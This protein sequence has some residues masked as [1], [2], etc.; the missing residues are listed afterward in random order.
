MAEPPSINAAGGAPSPLERLR[1][2]QVAYAFAP[3]YGLHIAE[4]FPRFIPWTHNFPRVYGHDMTIASFWAGDIMFIAYVL[5][6]LLLLRFNRSGAGVVAALSVSVW[7]LSNG[8]KHIAMTLIFNSYSPGAL[9]AAGL[10]LP[11]SVL[12]FDRAAHERLLTRRRVGL[13]AGLGLSVQFG[14]LG[15][16][17]L[18]A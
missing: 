16:G 9:V 7:A 11:L 1:F 2:D 18:L 8:L 3:A 10:Y 12:L 15:L 14:V 5:T 13:A 17:H 6:C 4:E